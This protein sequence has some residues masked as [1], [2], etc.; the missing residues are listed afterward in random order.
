M[1][2]DSILGFTGEFKFMAPMHHSPVQL[3]EDQT[4]TYPTVEHA[5]AASKVGGDAAAKD[6][7]LA[8]DDPVAAKR[9]GTKALG[10]Q[11]LPAASRTPPRPRPRG[12]RRRWAR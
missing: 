8:E 4:R 5:L 2:D 10:K 1:G 12:A 7:I 9:L 11:G 3:P 6:A